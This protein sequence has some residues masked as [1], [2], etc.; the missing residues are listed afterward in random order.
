MEKRKIKKRGER[1]QGKGIDKRQGKGK[2]RGERFAGKGGGEKEEKELRIRVSWKRKRSN[3]K[4]LRKKVAGERKGTRPDTR[5]K[6]RLVR[7]KP[8]FSRC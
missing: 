2:E 7:D 5:H 8:R 1:G 6:M 4:K 3:R